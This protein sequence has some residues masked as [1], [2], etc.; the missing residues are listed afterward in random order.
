MAYIKYQFE[1]PTRLRAVFIGAGGHAFRNVYPTFQYAPIDLVAI[2]DL[3]L[4]R[5]Q[6]YGRIFGGAKAYS[7]YQEML[8][9]EQPDIAFVVASYDPDGRVQA[10]AIAEACLAAGV[11]VWMEKPTAATSAEVRHLR[12]LSLA[13][14]LVCMTGIKKVF[15]PA[16]QKLKQI[17]TSPE[18]GPASS[19]L[20]RYPQPLPPP[21]VRGDGHAMLDVLDHIYHPGAV[22]SFLGGPAARLSYEW[23]PTAGATIATLLF[24]SGVIGA[25]HL[26][27][28]PGAGA[29]LE[30]IEVTGAGGQ[31][32]IDNGVRVTYYRSRGLLEYGRE[33]SYLVDEAHAPLLWEPEFS[34]GQLYNKNLFYLGYVPEVLHFCEAVLGEHSLELG[35]LD[36]ALQIM[37]LYDTFRRLQAG[38]PGPVMND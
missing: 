17:I 38:T 20:V 4:D 24:Q 37:A 34:L 6:S 23:E 19:I 3:H 22:L 13:H 1:Y 29:P 8:D 2:A 7:N 32:V 36:D 16:M 30:R 35:T 12:D 27:P 15:T 14:E 10:T 18:F 11:H 31:V 21:E 33:S 28:Y 9:I 25:L 26:V 5:A